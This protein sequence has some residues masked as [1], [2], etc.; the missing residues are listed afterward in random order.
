MKT[1]KYTSK[2]NGTTVFVK[3][4]SASVRMYAETPNAPVPR[5][6][7]KLLR[8]TGIISR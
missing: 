5:T 8:T 7:S 6:T 4:Y 2:T 1:D 3:G